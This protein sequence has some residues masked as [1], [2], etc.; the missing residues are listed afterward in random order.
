MTLMRKTSQSSTML[1]TEVQRKIKYRQ[2]KKI[3]VDG[4]L[5][6]DAVSSK[7]DWSYQTMI[8]YAEDVMVA[9]WAFGFSCPCHRMQARSEYMRRVF[10]H[11]PFPPG[12]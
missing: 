8:L 6:T 12:M 11:V 5:I 3:L 7:Y 1:M 4:P 10:V 9:I 2:T